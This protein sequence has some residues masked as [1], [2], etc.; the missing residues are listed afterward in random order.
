M[1][2]ERR[3]LKLK[4]WKGLIDNI[5]KEYAEKNQ[6]FYNFI[7]LKYFIKLEPSE[8]E[9]TVIYVHNMRSK[10]MFSELGNY[11]DRDFYNS[12][13]IIKIYTP[14]QNYIRRLTI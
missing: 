12:H 13:R 7:H 9:E 2:I 14:N 3:I 4:K 10:A 11:L 8:I 1:D 6:E 5:V